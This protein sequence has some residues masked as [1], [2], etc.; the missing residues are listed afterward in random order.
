[1]PGKRSRMAFLTNSMRLLRIVEK[2]SSH[3]KPQS[4]S[5]DMMRPVILKFTKVPVCVCVSVCV[6]V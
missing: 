5:V 2:S 3:E 6:C 4:N 1:M